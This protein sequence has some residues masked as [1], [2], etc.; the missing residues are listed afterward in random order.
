MTEALYVLI[1]FAQEFATIEARDPKPWTE[2][3]TL[4]V[5]SAHGVQVALQH[6]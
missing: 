1:R 2:L 3:L 6:A 4:T 5:S